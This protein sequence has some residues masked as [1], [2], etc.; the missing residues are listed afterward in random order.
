MANHALAASYAAAERLSHQ[1][2]LLEAI[3][4]LEPQLSLPLTEHKETQ[5]SALLLLASL[6]L[7]QERLEVCEKLLKAALAVATPTQSLDIHLLRARVYDFRGHVHKA[8][9]EWEK[10]LSLAQ[11]IDEPTYL[12]VKILCLRENHTFDEA[13]QTALE[14]I[15]RGSATHPQYVARLYYL[16]AFAAYSSGRYRDALQWATKTIPHPQASASQKTDCLRLKSLCSSQEGNHE[17]GLEQLKAAT[18]LAR[19]GA[20]WDSAVNLALSTAE[21]LVLLGQLTDAE[22]L[23]EEI[24][25]RFPTVAPLTA[26]LKGNCALLRGEL[27]QAR[28]ALITAR[29]HT[30]RRGT[31]EL[32]TASLAREEGRYPEALQEIEALR[33]QGSAGPEV[34]LLRFLHVLVLWQCEKYSEAEQERAALTQ[35]VSEDFPREIRTRFLQMEAR[36][37]YLREDW[38]AGI[39]AWKQVL[40]LEPHPIHQPENWAQLGDGYAQLGESDAARFAWEKAAAQPV[41]SVWVRRAKE[42]LEL[43]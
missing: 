17:E 36:L 20:S 5:H 2:K 29:K 42:R 43:G 19:T 37:A 30:K 27:A 10:A 23:C 31:H 28:E 21:R 40:R 41:E 14:A 7:Y 34:Y 16:A 13:Y 8:R 1:G 3:A 4:L 18:Y 15:T 12:L 35:E 39:G 25:R 6:Y 22:A 26:I 33:A 9:G 11:T 38:S 32:L 24:V